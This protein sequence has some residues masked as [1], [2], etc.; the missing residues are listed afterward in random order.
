MLISDKSHMGTN[1]GTNPG[2]VQMVGID[3]KNI[4]S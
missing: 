3:S 1:A 2:F 4:G